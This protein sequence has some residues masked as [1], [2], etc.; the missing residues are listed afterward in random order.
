MVIKFR[1]YLGGHYPNIGTTLVTRIIGAIGR[2]WTRLGIKTTCRASKK[3][4][5]VT[6]LCPIRSGGIN[7]ERHHPGRKSRRAFRAGRTSNF[8]YLQP[9]NSLVH[10]FSC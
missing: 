5:V 8:E 3:G 4:I 7:S 1:G 6:F 10:T 2:N 9:H